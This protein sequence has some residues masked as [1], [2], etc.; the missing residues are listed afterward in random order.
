VSNIKRLLAMIGK[1]KTSVGYTVPEGYFANLEAR[2][3]KIPSDAAADASPVYH[4]KGRAFPSDAMARRR[5][6]GLRRVAARHMAVA[7]SLL[8]LLAVGAA[9]LSLSGGRSEEDG[10]TMFDKMHLADLVPVS[11]PYLVRD[12]GVADET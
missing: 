9:W 8:L 1:D 5:P 11:D 6:L 12:Y 10:L 4:G 7:A 3:C 2:L